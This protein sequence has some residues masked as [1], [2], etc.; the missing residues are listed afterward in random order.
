MS[1]LGGSTVAH[2]KFACSVQGAFRVHMVA[3]IEISLQMSGNWMEGHMA[4]E[5][6]DSFFVS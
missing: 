4:S 6:A 1:H 5:V 3:R 2:S